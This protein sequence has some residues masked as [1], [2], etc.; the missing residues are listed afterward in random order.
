MNKYLYLIPS[1][2]PPTETYKADLADR[3]LVE[4]IHPVFGGMTVLVRYQNGDRK[5]ETAIVSAKFLFELLV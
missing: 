5:G 2:H 3:V 1:D 4:E